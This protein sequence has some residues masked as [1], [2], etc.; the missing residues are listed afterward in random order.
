MVLSSWWHDKVF[1]TLFLFLIS[2]IKINVYFLLIEPITEKSCH[3]FKQDYN[4]NS[5]KWCCLFF[6]YKL[7]PI[8]RSANM[9]V[10]VQEYKLKTFLI[11]VATCLYFMENH[12]TCKLTCKS[13]TLIM[14]LDNRLLVN[15]TQKW[16]NVLIGSEIKSKFA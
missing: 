6:F 15:M 4:R 3:R 7:D 11:S 13:K 9:S 5:F 2:E 8:Y 16:I 10:S 1:D 12:N 14:Y